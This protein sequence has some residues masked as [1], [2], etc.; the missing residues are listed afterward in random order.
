MRTNPLPF[1]LLVLCGCLLAALGCDPLR[2]PMSGATMSEAEEMFVRFCQEEFG[3]AVSTR[4]VGQTLWIYHPMEEPITVI[5]ASDKGAHHSSQYEDRLTVHYM[6]SLFTDG[7]FL[8]KYD[9]GMDRIY[10]LDYGYLSNYSEEYQTRQRLL[11]GAVQHAFFDVGVIP[12]N[13]GKV[14]AIED[15]KHQDFI[16]GYMA[17]DDPPTFVVIVIADIVTGIE[18][19]SQIYFEDLKRAMTMAQSLPQEEFHKRYVTDLRGHTA[20]IGDVQGEHLPYRNIKLE[21]FMARQVRQRVKFKYQSSIFPP[22]DDPQLEI[23]EAVTDTVNGYKFENFSSVELFDI[24]NKNTA[25]WST[26]DVLNF[27]HPNKRNLTIVPFSR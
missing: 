8:V 22:G 15:D 13:R 9:I 16:E 6:E 18:V 2:S 20:M 14:N 1:K 7:A 17:T 27:K 25:T 26:S 11:L 4:L 3:Y 12:G 10:D 5:E 19:E 24:K 23:I 21:N